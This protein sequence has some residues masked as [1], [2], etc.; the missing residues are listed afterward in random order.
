MSEAT[1]TL[2]GEGAYLHGV[3]AASSTLGSTAVVASKYLVC[4][5]DWVALVVIG[6]WP[7]RV[8]CMHATSVSPFPWCAV[9]IVYH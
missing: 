1:E 3:G 5:I 7:V 6:L 9:C 8:R 4:W 2:E